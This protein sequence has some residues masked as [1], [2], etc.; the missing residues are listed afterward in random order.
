MFQL[1]LPFPLHVRTN[2]SFLIPFLWDLFPPKKERGGKNFRFFSFRDEEEVTSVVFLFFLFYL[3]LASEKDE[4][5]SLSAQRSARC[6]ADAS[7]SSNTPADIG[8]HVVVA[9][10][11]PAM[12]CCLITASLPEIRE[13]NT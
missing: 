7:S 3:R 4:G 5:F 9:A 11:A 13:G 1:E 10:V 12:V 6:T 8:C 2:F